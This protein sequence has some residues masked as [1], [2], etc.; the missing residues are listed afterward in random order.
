MGRIHA[1]QVKAG[2]ALARIT[3]KGE[4]FPERARY[5]YIHQG[6][7]KVEVEAAEAGEIVAIAGL[8]NIAIGETLA[9]P[10]TP[11]ALPPIFVEEPTVRM[12]FGVT[13]P[14]LW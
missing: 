2:Q 5:L 10:I 13:P 12:T 11:I 3:T 4:I 8:E 6:L 1:G 14:A 7:D 9:D